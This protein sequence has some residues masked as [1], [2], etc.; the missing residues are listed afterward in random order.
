MR[1]LK[2]V[3][4]NTIILKSEDSRLNLVLVGGRD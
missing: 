4:Q 3:D 2:E 1:I